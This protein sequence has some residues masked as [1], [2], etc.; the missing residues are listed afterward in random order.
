MFWRTCIV[1]IYLASCILSLSAKSN[2]SPYLLD[3]DQSFAGF[4]QSI[5]LKIKSFLISFIDH[6]IF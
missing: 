4:T 2:N 5:S 1:S 6:N 3:L